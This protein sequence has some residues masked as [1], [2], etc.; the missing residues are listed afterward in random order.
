[1]TLAARKD[2]PSRQY[3]KNTNAPGKLRLRQA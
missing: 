3:M 2:T 1:M